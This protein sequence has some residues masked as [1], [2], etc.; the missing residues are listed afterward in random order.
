[1]E[2]QHVMPYRFS[3]FEFDVEKV[4]LRRG[5]VLVPLEPQVFAV[6]HRLLENRD[7]VV[8]RD[9]LIE[10]VWAG[11]FVSESVI[12]SRIKSLRVALGDDGKSQR[13]VRTIHGRGFRFVED[14]VT[15]E[16]TGN[17]AS[18]RESA[19]RRMD[20]TGPPT[21]GG[22]P[23]GN[24]ETAPA[25]GAGHRP[26]I[27]VLPFEMLTADDRYA[28]IA[29]AFPHD[30]IA[31]LSRLRW[32]FVIARGSSFKFSP[33]YP[34]LRQVGRLLSVRYCLSGVVEIFGTTLTVNVELADTRDA[35]VVWSERYTATV[36]EI[37]GVRS[38]IVSSIITALEIQIPLR[39]AQR[40][41]L[42]APE[43]LD[44]WSAYHVGLQHLLRFTRQDNAIARAMFERAIHLEPS[45]RSGPCRTVLGLFPGCV[46]E[47]YRGSAP[48][49]VRR[50][51]ACGEKR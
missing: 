30:L 51:R 2:K 39:E 37:H 46:P 3:D 48:G 21:S 5:G 24:R 44:A 22:T 31:A 40:A 42:G 19:V 20:V 23:D 9:E 4:E 32:L 16:G 6:L 18:G 33:P 43:Q 49:A 10:T 7:R 45:F 25:G 17:R 1:M 26:S 14:V 13:F 8:S 34:D 12:S 50:P 47:V 15:E 36:D 35:S 29:D 41:R 38:E 11:R 28:P 27:A